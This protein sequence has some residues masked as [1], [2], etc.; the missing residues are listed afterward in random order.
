MTVP[1]CSEPVPGG[2]EPHLHA[3]FLANRKLPRVGN[4]LV[5]QSE[6][7][8]VWQIALAPGERLPFHR[9]VLNYFWTATSPGR[10]RS[11]YADGRVA[12]VTYVQGD[13]R[14][15][16]FAAGDSMYHDLENLGD[17]V[18]TFVTVEYLQSPNAPLAL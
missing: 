9:H 17:S 15:Y 12:E 4:V 14:H 18:L 6:R 7:V 13:T 11:R 16:D 8:R 10:A 5:S 1:H 3:E 2:L